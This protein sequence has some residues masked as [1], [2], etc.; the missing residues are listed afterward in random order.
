MSDLEPDCAY[1]YSW[2]LLEDE[3][4][5]DI[6]QGLRSWMR[7]QTMALCDGS[8]RCPEGHG[9]VVYRYDFERFMV[10]Q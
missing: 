6:Y 7:G 8:G 10:N 5:P 4:P 2:G 1:G 9:G 3:L